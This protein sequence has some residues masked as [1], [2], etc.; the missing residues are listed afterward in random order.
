MKIRFEKQ[1]FKK[2]ATINWYQQLTIMFKL[3]IQFYENF[4][5]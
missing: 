1:A 3:I 4:I 2:I 5:N